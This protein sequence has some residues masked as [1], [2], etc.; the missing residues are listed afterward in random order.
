MIESFFTPYESL[1]FHAQKVVVLAPHPDDEVLGCGG[2][3]AQL[4]QQDDIQITVVILSQG[5][6]QGPHPEARL[7]ESRRAQAILGYS[8][9]CAEALPDGAMATNT[10]LLEETITQ[11][12]AE[13]QPDLVFCPSI[14]EMHRDHR[15]VAEATLKVLSA[16]S[17]AST[18]EA[19][20]T[21]VAMYEVGRPLSCN[22]LV[23]ITATLEL[24]QSA[25]A[26]FQS[27]L[28]VQAYDRQVLGLNQFRSYTLPLN[29]MAAEAF[30]TV[31]LPDIEAF[32]SQYHPDQV[33]EALY[34]AN[35][36]CHQL[37]QQSQAT[38]AQLEALLHSRSWR[39][40]SPLRTFLYKCRKVRKK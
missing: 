28:A 5:E 19:H 30:H 36:R 4:S 32:L 11:Y 15:A 26:Q 7:E 6:Q 18:A 31:A 39:W 40:T 29:V 10:P 13:Y 22:R 34:Q 12:L 33:S 37:A 24:K 16:L 25:I 35:R 3:L 21:Q 9:L 20:L 14:W 1:P 27:Q 2:T 38:T 17:Q 8:Q 23:D